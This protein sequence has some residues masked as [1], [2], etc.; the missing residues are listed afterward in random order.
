MSEL[1]AARNQEAAASS[2]GRRRRAIL[3]GIVL[4]F[5]DSA[6][7][8]GSKHLL[9]G[10]GMDVSSATVRND[11]AVLEQLGLIFQP[12]T[13]AGRVPTDRGFRTFV[14]ELLEAATLSRELAASL[15]RGVKQVAAEG[16]D[17]V[18]A[19]RLARLLSG[20]SEDVSFVSQP[21]RGRTT[22]AG[23]HALL[24]EPEAKDLGWVAELFR[25]LED[26]QQLA[27]SL[28]AA[29]QLQRG[30]DPV[31]F[32]I[33]SE[34]VQGPLQRCTIVLSSSRDPRSGEPT[35]VGFV[36]PTRIDY[37]RTAGFLRSLADLLDP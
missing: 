18:R 25:L 9:E 19:D 28:Q 31:S 27:A 17:S 30:D 24:E 7:P 12:F 10:L 1:D 32:V 4:E 33:G 34:N 2:L 13:S 14:D 36:G 21:E 3:R 20:L 5:V 8:V 37:R 35:I 6:E 15:Q 29:A 23:L 22:I 16:D 11:M 26:P